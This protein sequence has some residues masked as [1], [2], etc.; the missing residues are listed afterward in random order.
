MD[1]IQKF[2]VSKLGYSFLPRALTILTQPNPVRY[3]KALKA[4]SL[5][6]QVA[7]KPSA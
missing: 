3:G 4:Q 6:I 2:E 7:S 1:I 5:G